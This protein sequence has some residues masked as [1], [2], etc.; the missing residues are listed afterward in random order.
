MT[1][2]MELGYRVGLSGGDR[3]TGLHFLF[4]AVLGPRLGEG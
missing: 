1:L 3:A 2:R 4:G